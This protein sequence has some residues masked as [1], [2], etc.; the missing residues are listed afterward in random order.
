MPRDRGDVRRIMQEAAV[1]LFL[2]NGFDRTTAAEIA[3]RA[4]VTERTFFRHFPD[5]RDVLFD[6]ADLRARLAAA[7]SE[8]PPDFGP[9]AAVAWAFKAIAPMFEKNRPISEPAQAVIGRTPALLERQL[10]KTASLVVMI[11]DGLRAR[12]VGTHLADLGAAVGMAVAAQALQM[13]FQDSSVLLSNRFDEAFL[14]LGQL[15]ET[16]SETLSMAHD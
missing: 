7:I 3:A 2:A 4:G 14:A 11:A 10:S 13:W 12:D 8:A 1:E 9:L 5:K 6:E 15:S 16:A